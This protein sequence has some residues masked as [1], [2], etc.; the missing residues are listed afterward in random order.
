MVRPLGSNFGP[1]EVF[2]IVLFAV[3][4]VYLWSVFTTSGTGICTQ[5]DIVKERFDC[6]KVGQTYEKTEFIVPETEKLEGSSLWIVKLFILGT[7]VFISYLVVMKFVN[8]RPSRR[9]M[10][11]L[12]FMVVVVYL[13]WVYLIE[14][15]NLLGATTFEQLNLDRIGQKAAQMLGVN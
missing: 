9:D 7:A 1:K 4:G 8:G 5:E 13:I 14:P 10:V 12:I 11:S 15:T 6:V 3:I 2:M